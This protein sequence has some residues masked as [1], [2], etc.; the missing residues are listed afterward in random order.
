MEI[1]K[2]I[3]LYKDLKILLDKYGKENLIKVLNTFE[4]E[5][6]AES[7][8]NTSATILTTSPE[9]EVDLS[10]K[11]KTDGRGKTRKYSDQQVSMAL[12]STKSTIIIAKK[13]GIS[14]KQLRKYRYRWKQQYPHLIKPSV[15]KMEE[16]KEEVTEQSKEKHTET[17]TLSP[18][19]KPK[20]NKC[21]Y[22]FRNDAME[23][24]DLCKTCDENKEQLAR[25]RR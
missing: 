16:N 3:E 2:T 23:D 8:L 7:F 12:N 20:P 13:F 4:E 18:P 19:E 11:K 22:C 5:T 25:D 24:S 21:I 14:S 17:A 6:L 10:D 9:F 1:N 15:K